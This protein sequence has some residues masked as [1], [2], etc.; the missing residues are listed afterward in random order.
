ME[1]IFI[2]LVLALF[3]YEAYT[4]YTPEYGDTIS[5]LIWKASADRPLIPFLF[6]V[7]MGHLFWPAS[8]VWARLK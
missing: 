2:V 7:L 5:E 6:G 4:L 1:W 3:V 8:D